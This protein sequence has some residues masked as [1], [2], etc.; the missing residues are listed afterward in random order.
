MSDQAAATESSSLP[1][2]DPRR[3]APALFSARGKRARSQHS[4]WFRRGSTTQEPR[5][6]QRSH[7]KA[8]ALI[9]H[10]P[11]AHRVGFYTLSKSTHTLD[12]ILMRKLC[13]VFCEGHK[14]C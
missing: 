2:P 1:I 6:H 10:F 8:P 14:D 4:R 7:S 11:D 13:F 5:R 9:D 12:E 3:A